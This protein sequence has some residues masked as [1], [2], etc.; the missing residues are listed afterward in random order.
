[1]VY[2]VGTWSGENE[3]ILVVAF[4]TTDGSDDDKIN[5]R[6]IDDVLKNLKIR[7]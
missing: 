1:M 5:Q 3:G 6:L 2:N 7:R 4:Q